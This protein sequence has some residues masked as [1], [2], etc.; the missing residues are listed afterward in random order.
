MIT[1]NAYIAPPALNT[2]NGV[3]DDIPEDDIPIAH[4]TCIGAGC[5]SSVRDPMGFSESAAYFKQST[6]AMHQD[7]VEELKTSGFTDGLIAKLR[8][9]TKEI[10]MR[11][12]IL[13]NS[14]SMNRNDGCRVVE[15]ADGKMKQVACTRWAELQDCMN[16]HLDL[17]GCM[18]TPTVLRFLNDPGITTGPQRMSICE[19]AD[20]SRV[21]NLE[22]DIFNAKTMIRSVRPDGVTPLVQH[23]REI[24]AQV[25]LI[26]PELSRE[27]KRVVVIVAT[28]GLP[29]TTGDA[30]DSHSLECREFLEML[31]DLFKLP[32]WVN[33]RLCTRDEHVVNFYGDIDQQMELSVDVL[34]DFVSE[35][36]EVYRYNMW[37][38][39]AL[40]LHRCREMG[41]ENRLLDLLDE[42]TLTPGEIHKFCVFLFGKEDI[43][44]P[45][46]DWS[47]FKRVIGRCCEVEGKLYNVVKKKK[48]AW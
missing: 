43:P 4:A 22:R 10:P 30:E 45:T 16:D 3:Q 7:G 8:D 23:I 24:E 44:N 1:A 33:I 40:P 25:R 14:G 38:N 28:D 32:V 18:R 47:G 26:E 12:W 48:T 31:T 35:A 5:E 20:Q 21:N 19:N 6:K 42:R 34:S 27:G 13:D 11:I 37:L 39:Y 9:N 46:M 36:H 15:T 41:H 2:T 29:N 17:M